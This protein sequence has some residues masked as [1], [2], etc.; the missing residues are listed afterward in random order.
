M[1]KGRK[2]VSSKRVKNDAKNEKTIAL[3]LIIVIVIF[4]I[5][6]YKI[7]DLLVLSNE[8]INLSGESYYQYFY[9]VM[10][11]YSGDMKIVE[12][13]NDIQMVLENGEVIYLDTTPIYYKDVLGKVLFAK[14]MELVIPDVSYY[15]LSKFTNVIEENKKVYVK[16]FNKKNKTNVNNGFLFDGN[17]LYFFL[18]ETTVKIGEMEYE[19]SPFS[20]VIVNY[21]NS[22]EIYNYEKEDYTIISDEEQ[23][24]S[25]VLA[26]NNFRNY[27]VN[28]SVDSLMTEKSQHLLIGNTSNLND[29]DY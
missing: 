14:E 23:L 24:A 29:F 26:V 16:K 10:E 20:Y 7:F 22:V 12:K 11:E 9:G 8:K 4:F 6:L 15:K 1:T 13:N 2:N 3:W 18:E 28:M 5:V 25:D 21:R 17:D 19:L 27:T